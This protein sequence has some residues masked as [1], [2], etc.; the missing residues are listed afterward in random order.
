MKTRIRRPKHTREFIA[1]EFKK[2]GYKLI[3]KTYKSSKQIL[4]V[5]CKKGHKWAVCW[6][7]F[8]RGR[9]CRQ[10]FIEQQVKGNKTLKKI[11]LRD[12]FYS[13]SD[14]ARILGVKD[15]DLRYYTGL[16]LLPGPTNEHGIKKYYKMPDIKKIERMIE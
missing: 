15:A 1:A 14:A 9:R 8:S 10:C 2:L 7:N 5:R 4:E 6:N 12:K 3:T 11:V 13:I 16:G